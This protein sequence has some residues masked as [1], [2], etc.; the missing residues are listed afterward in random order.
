MLVAE[1]LAAF[2][3]FSIFT[4]IGQSVITAPGISF[5]AQFAFN[6][7]TGDFPPTKPPPIPPL[8][9]AVTVRA[10]VCMTRRRLVV[11]RYQLCRTGHIDISICLGP[12]MT[13]LC[14]VACSAAQQTRGPASLHRD[15]RAT[16]RVFTISP[17]RPDLVVAPTTNKRRRR[18]AMVGENCLSIELR[19][20]NAER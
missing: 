13:A 4:A 18:A 7:V 5:T 15:T 14:R 11:R 2:N 1:L 9:A 19:R 3:R 8:H 17:S 6:G 12:C 10:D 20:R 16:D